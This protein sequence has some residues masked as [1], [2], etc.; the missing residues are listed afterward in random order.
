MACMVSGAGADD[1]GGIRETPGAGGKYAGFLWRLVRFLR[2][3]GCRLLSG[4][5]V[6]EMDD[7]RE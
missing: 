4:M 3:L 2:L 5:P 1:Q 6:R 7:E